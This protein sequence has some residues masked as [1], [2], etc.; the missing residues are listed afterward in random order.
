MQPSNTRQNVSSSSS[1]NKDFS[2]GSVQTYATSLQVQNSKA[3]A[4]SSQFKERLVCCYQCCLTSDLV[5][6]MQHQKSP[7]DVT[8]KGWEE[9]MAQVQ[10]RK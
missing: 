6:R 2:L 7:T 10:W 9:D 1:K 8:N 4:L 3:N 5:P